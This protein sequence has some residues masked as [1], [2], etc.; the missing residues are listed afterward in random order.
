MVK[1]AAVQM[2]IQLGQTHLNKERILAYAQNTPADLLVFPEC[3]NSGYCFNSLEDAMPHAEVVPG[4]FTDSLLSVARDMGRS[5]AVGILEKKGAALRNTAVL[6]TPE[7]NLRVYRKS[8]LPYLGVDR[9]VTPGSELPIFQTA[10][11]RVGMIICYECRFPEVAR[12]MSLQGADL[13]IGLSNWPVG[14]M[15]I[16]TLLVAARAAENHVWIVSS[17]RVGLEQGSRFIGKSMII[18]PDGQIIA[19]LPEGNEET[20]SAD[21]DLSISKAKHF[22]R[23]PKAYEIDLFMDRRPEL[24]GTVTQEG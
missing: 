4:A 10:F 21:L 1:A 16:P 18:D 15:V 13:L 9:F 7:G 14:A 8:H 17:N 2:D 19:S 23:K 5:L 11:G 24:Y 22:V 20:V 6:A 3:A 12:S